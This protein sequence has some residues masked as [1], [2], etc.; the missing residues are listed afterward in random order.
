[1]GGNNGRQSLQTLR[2]C[3]SSHLGSLPMTC[4]EEMR[5]ETSGMG[6][7]EPSWAATSRTV[8]AFVKTS[9]L[10]VLDFADFIDLT[11]IKDLAMVWLRGTF[12]R[13]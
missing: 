13:W 4:A 5:D 6:M 11:N 12:E 3:A 2:N 10:T 7:A 8:E 9:S 1:M